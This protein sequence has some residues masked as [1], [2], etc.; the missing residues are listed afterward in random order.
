M[1]KRA[2]D[3][4]VKAIG[5]MMRLVLTLAPDARLRAVAY[6]VSWLGH[7]EIAERIYAAAQSV[8]ERQARTVEAGETP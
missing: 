2:A 7:P 5:R 4:E 3:P 8:R 1:T 6:V